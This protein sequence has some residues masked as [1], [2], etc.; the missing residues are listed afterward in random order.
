MT[1]SISQFLTTR[2]GRVFRWLSCAIL[3]IS[4]PSGNLS[5]QPEEVQVQK[6]WGHSSKPAGRSFLTAFGEA[7]YSVREGSIIES[8]A[9][10]SGKLIWSIDV[11]G[12]VSSNL[13]SDG[14]SVYF[15]R[16]SG[17]VADNVSGTTLMSI[18]ANAGIT[19]WKVPL[20]AGE[21]Y[22]L[23]ITKT[24]ILLITGSGEV[25]VLSIADGSIVS[26][27]K[28]TQSISLETPDLGQR[29]IFSTIE[30]DIFAVDGTE[31]PQLMS[32]SESAVTALLPEAGG[33]VFYGNDRGIL[34]F[35]SGK[36]SRPVWQFKS[37]GAISDI[38]LS[39][40]RIIAASN[41]NFVYA[42]APA[43]GARLWKRRVSGRVSALK[44]VGED[45]LLVQP[46]SDDNIVI[47]NI[48]NGS[49]AGQ[50]PATA[51]EFVLGSVVIDSNRVVVATGEA[52]YGYAI[53]G[54]RT[55]K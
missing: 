44:M 24:G 21:E 17:G 37:G 39:D 16:R 28:F 42:L 6:C 9:V 53:G 7:I 25:S 12:S 50:I 26:S 2:H 15:V 5:A 54:C 40:G 14:Q 22:K 27:R 11:G 36:G 20:R 43:N 3:L 32:R 8:L 29:S 19:R 18:S 1:S 31:L 23:A 34:A 38:I 33:G 52:L 30:K 35:L 45:L 4:V 49:V 41:D 46:L 51:G 55:G 10:D 47:L 48:K 13:V